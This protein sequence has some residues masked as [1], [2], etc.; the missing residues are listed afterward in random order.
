MPLGAEHAKDP[1]KVSESVRRTDNVPGGEAMF[2]C[3]DVRACQTFEEGCHDNMCHE[4]K[5]KTTNSSPLTTRVIMLAGSSCD[6]RSLELVR[7]A[8][9]RNKNTTWLPEKDAVKGGINA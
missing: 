3:G 9:Q 6:I 4:E 8:F 7:M 1:Q 5:S 2:G